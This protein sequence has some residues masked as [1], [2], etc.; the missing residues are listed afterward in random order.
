VYCG[1][2]RL[3]LTLRR[4][5]GSS[6]YVLFRAGERLCAVPVQHVVETMRP[7]PIEPFRDAPAFV[8]GLAMIRGA[9]VPVVDAAALFHA[10]RAGESARFL[11]LRVAGARRVALAVEEVLGVEEI[12]PASTAAVPALL[13]AARGEAVDA[14]GALDG[15]LLVVLRAGRVLPEAAWAALESRRGPS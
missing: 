15:E 11:V 12:P 8:R 6:R 14:V 2:I 9:T 4:L 13:G 10:T 7:L 3:R 1:A 5:V